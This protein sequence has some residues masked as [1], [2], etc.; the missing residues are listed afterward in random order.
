MDKTVHIPALTAVSAAYTL[1][2]SPFIPMALTGTQPILE[3]IKRSNRPLVCV[4][5][6]GGTDAYAS[7]LGFARVLKNLAKTADIVAA[8]GASPK[9]LRFLKEHAAVRTSVD[10]MHRFTIELDAS[11]ANV[12]ELSYEVKDGKVLIHLHPSSGTW[13]AQDVNVH[14]AGYRY[15]LIICIGAPDLESIGALYR[16][17]PEF[18]FN[19]PIINIDHTPENEHYGALNVVDLTAS[20]CGEVC[21]DLFEGMDA[22]LIDE[23]S[24]TAFLTGMIAK[25]KSFKR[26]NLTPKTL[27]TA[28]KLVAR[29]AR[30]EEIVQNLYR[31][32][33]VQTLRL[34]GRA[35][36]RLK[37]DPQ[38]PIVWT[39]LSRQD[40]LHAGAEEADL[41]DVIDELITSSPDARMV[42]LI[43]EAADGAVHAVVH[44]ERPF[45][46][47]ALTGALKSTGTR[48][49]AHVRF[50]EPSIV[51]A[52]MACLEALRKGL[53][54]H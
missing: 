38:H 15:D 52:E 17:H 4:P 36:A 24:A 10:D 49:H 18:F 48:E 7:A 41:E 22:T 37:Q 19:T 27:A 54:G 5:A 33:T 45:D 20:S 46:A 29:G 2:H 14:D 8:D 28:G 25:T 32:R 43:Y 30:R 31:T 1:A 6:G 51:K 23:E 44:A 47:L 3:A 16:A 50:V 12:K 26:P 21:F 40:F 11:K 42:A 39:L 53:A 9:A 35:L 13:T 34:W